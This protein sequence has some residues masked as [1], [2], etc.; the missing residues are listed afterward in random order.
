MKK[1]AGIILAL[2]ILLINIL[3]V[4]GEGSEEDLVKEGIKFNEEGQFD[5][6]IKCFDEALAINPENTEALLEKGQAYIMLNNSIEAHASF[7]K[8]IEIDP[9]L[10]EPWRFKAIMFVVEGNIDKA[11][12]CYDK[13]I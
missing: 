12:E 1:S 9:T 7:D 5:K 6:A 3:P 8:A 4:M 13:A 11:I 10:P 2:L